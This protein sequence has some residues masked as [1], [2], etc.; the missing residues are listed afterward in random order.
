MGL[1]GS[2]SWL[3]SISTGS[4]NYVSRQVANVCFRRAGRHVARC[5]FQLVSSSV[6]LGL[7]KRKDWGPLIR[8][9]TARVGVTR[10]NRKLV[11]FNG[12]IGLDWPIIDLAFLDLDVF[13]AGILFIFVLRG[14]FTNMGGQKFKQPGPYLNPC[15]R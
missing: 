3:F 12:N 8:L 4:S 9:D 11:L 6:V 2:D 10:E 5:T 13:G 14:T 1:N 7:L 15:T